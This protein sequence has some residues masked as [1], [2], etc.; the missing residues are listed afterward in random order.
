[1]R[2]RILEILQDQRPDIDFENETELVS[3]GLLESFDI[4]SIVS[5]LDDEFDIEIT[6][7]ELKAEN[8]DSL[9]ALTKLIES[10]SEE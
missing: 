1:M 3:G 6:P 10:L 7:K 4:V 2:E 9:D 8:F 5:E